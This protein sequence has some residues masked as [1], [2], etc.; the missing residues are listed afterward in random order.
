MRGA[1]GARVDGGKEELFGREILSGIRSARKLQL[2]PTH[3][4]KFHVFFLQQRRKLLSRGGPETAL[5]G[6]A[7]TALPQAANGALP[8]EVGSVPLPAEVGNDHLP[9]EVGNVHLPAEV[10]GVR[11]LAK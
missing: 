7:E 10:G 5:S 2:S 9:A 1:D 8:A 4:N 3:S 6:A 11:L